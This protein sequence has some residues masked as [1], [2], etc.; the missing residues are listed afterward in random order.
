MKKLFYI[1]LFLFYSSI[2]SAWGVLD[3]AERYVNGNPD[4]YPPFLLEIIN[5]GRPINVS[6]NYKDVSNILEEIEDEDKRDYIKEH[7][8]MAAKYDAPIQDAIKAAVDEW[9]NA[10]L[11]TLGK[12][13]PVEKERFSDIIAAWNRDNL[14]NFVKFGSGA[15]ADMRVDVAMDW[16]GTRVCGDPEALACAGAGSTMRILGIYYSPTSRNEFP[17][18]HAIRHEFGHA[19]G[20]ADQNY[21]KEKQNHSIKYSTPYNAVSTMTAANQVSADGVHSKENAPVSPDDVEGVII[22]T[23]L[24]KPADQKTDRW[25]VGWKSFVRKNT[26][27]RLSRI[28]DTAALKEQVEIANKIRK[29]AA[30][31]RVNSFKQDLKNTDF[32]NAKKI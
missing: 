25:S 22:L 24:F 5:S 23:D 6:I 14:I 1:A 7:N 13:P 2:A 28:F 4:N 29:E 27:Y 20:L 12:L 21:P 32:K 17:L 11:N 31:K 16:Y 9:K 15:R 19:L 18:I 3:K 8:A 30:N 26:Y 10:I